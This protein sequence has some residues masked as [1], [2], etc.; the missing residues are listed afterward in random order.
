MKVIVLTQVDTPDYFNAKCNIIDINSVSTFFQVPYWYE[1]DDKYELSF[2]D[3]ELLG[4]CGFNLCATILEKY[5]TKKSSSRITGIA[6]IHKVKHLED[7]VEYVDVTEE[8]V[9][10]IKKILKE[11]EVNIYD[12]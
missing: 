12:C 9:E 3:G 10:Y 6:I 8:D 4:E 2:E 7:D 1:F 11:N 5:I